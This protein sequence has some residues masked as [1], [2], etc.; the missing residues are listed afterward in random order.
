MT[1]T[2]F[3]KTII[4]LDI[5]K[6][7]LLMN[8]QYGQIFNFQN[9]RATKLENSS[10]LEDLTGLLSRA[11]SR[12]DNGEH[13]FFDDEFYL[14]SIPTEPNSSYKQFIDNLKNSFVNSCD[15]KIC[16]IRG[17][18]GIGK[19]LFFEKGIQKLINSNNKCSDKYINMG[20]DFK[21]IDNDKDINFYQMEIYRQ[22]CDNAIDNIRELG[23]DIFNIFKQKYED[24]GNQYNTPKTYLFPL[25]FFCEE[26]FKKYGKPCII[27]FDNIDLSSVT[28]QTN[29]FKATTNICSRFNKFM[30][31]SNACN[32]YRMYFAMRPETL[33]HSE[34]ARIGDVINF[35]LPNLLKIFLATIKKVLEETAFELDQ[36]EALKCNITCNNII[37]GEHS[38]IELT[39]YI[40]V[41]N[42][43]C[44][45]L[46][47]Y[48]EDIW[49]N[50]NEMI[51]ER[52][53]TSEQFHC[54]IVN[55]NVR[56]FLN[57]M[58]DTISNG[59]FKPFTKEFNKTTSSMH[60][61]IFNYIEMII[62]GRWEIHP[63]NSFIDSEG[64]NKAPI[65][66]NVFD[67]SI[68]HKN[69]TDKLRHFMLNI[70]I[71]QYFYLHADNREIS[72]IDLK[73]SLSSFFS[74]D[75]ILRAV[76]KL[77]HIRMLYSFVEGDS[78][79]AAIKDWRNVKIE[80]DTRLK[81]SPTGQFYFE[82][83]I[84]EFEYLYQM[85]LSS[86]LCTDYVEELKL[87]W[88]TEKEQCVLLF[89]KS[90]FEIIKENIAEYEGADEID[91][92]ADLF[93]KNDMNCPY[94]RMLTSFISVMQNKVQRAEKMGTGSTEKL[95]DILN[96]A[97]ELL[98][99][100]KEYFSERLGEL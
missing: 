37:R 79:I 17:R 72:Y 75:N 56:T 94:V 69:T 63:G 51:C 25:K 27:I 7:C 87:C 8:K 2:E 35:P 44:R 13:Y 57:F 53:G 64:G 97:K 28:T 19:T 95:N 23:V 41:A 5:G 33:M 60:Y 42:Y 3:D 48:L 45:I 4:T 39:T 88:K 70:R 38:K 93:Y 85:S 65:I 59:G 18:A 77:T 81:L 76:K 83:L 15:S 86:L 80:D 61:N 73:E 91:N 9:K 58:A 99:N 71:L 34:E 55:Y 92:F 31:E 21:N 36:S 67:T 96:T 62:R 24:F 78:A 30:R 89:L 54:S 20:V 50:T 46:D 6:R 22:L 16:I 84:C 40:D 82:K 47:S 29:V 14:E 66:F 12:L 26:I 98:E 11:A 100:S 1:E 68:Y 52:L 74:D 90:I 49:N 32:Y 43:F 10:Y